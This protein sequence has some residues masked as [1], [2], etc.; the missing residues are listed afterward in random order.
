M[1]QTV[2]PLA[3][4]ARKLGTQVS[5]AKGDHDALIA[6]SHMLRT[7]DPAATLVREGESSAACVVLLSGFAFREKRTSQGKRQIVSVYVPGDALNFDRLFLNAMDEDVLALTSADIAIIPRE[8]VLELARS[9]PAVADAMVASTL[10]EGSISREWMLNIGRRDGLS[11]VA[12]LLC[13]FAVRLDAV[14]QV[15]GKKMGFHLPMSQD[16]LAD[17]LGLTP[18]HVNRMLK[19]LEADGLIERKGRWVTFPQWDELCEIAD[20]SSRYLHLI[21][22]L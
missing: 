2:S 5:L 7:C 4:M 17:A 20:F 6:L 16:Q 18:V 10:V 12:H 13:E 3:V 15:Y 22:R 8:A 19:S 21:D 11:R 9:R 14:G 1:L